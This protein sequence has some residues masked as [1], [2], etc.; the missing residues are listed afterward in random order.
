M[1]NRA[2]R[3]RA[4]LETHGIDLFYDGTLSGSRDIQPKTALHVLAL[5]QELERLFNFTPKGSFIDDP[6]YGVD[7]Q[8]LIGTRLDP[9]V[10]VAD[11]YL[12]AKRALEHPSFRDR[13]RI[14]FLDTIWIPTQPNVIRILGILEVFG[15]ESSYV[16]IGPYLVGEGE[17]N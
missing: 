14:A 3:N 12:E 9:R 8:R 7:L 13:F 1:F 4:L 10:S 15:F 17:L 11:A 5:K 2:D 16:Q 6:E